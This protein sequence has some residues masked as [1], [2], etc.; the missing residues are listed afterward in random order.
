MTL[1]YPRHLP[2]HRD[3][4][5]RCLVRGHGVIRHVAVSNALAVGEWTP[6]EEKRILLAVREER[7]NVCLVVR[8]IY[9]R[10]WNGVLDKFLHDDAT[11][12]LSRLA[13]SIGHLRNAS[14]VDRR[15]SLIHLARQN[16]Q[17]AR[18]RHGYLRKS[19]VSR[20]GR[21]EG[22]ES[23]RY[24]RPVLRVE[25]EDHGTIVEQRRVRYQRGPHRRTAV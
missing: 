23:Y 20:R 1:D 6:R 9:Q 22:E 7:I 13:A 10:Q 12:K 25:P 5:V 3:Q 11:E 14:V 8:G 15:Q 17:L 4:S 18:E 2:L 24:L 16:Q 19:G 21:V